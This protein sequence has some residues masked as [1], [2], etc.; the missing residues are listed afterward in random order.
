[1]G[2]RTLWKPAV[3]QGRGKDRNYFEGWYFKV[4]DADA[5]HRYAVIPGVF[6]GQTPET[7]HSF[8]QTLDGATGQA[9]YH[10]YA[11][12]DFRAAEDTFDVWVG[13]NH[14]QLDTITLDISDEQRQMQGELHFERPIGW[15]VTTFSPGIMGW[16]A[17]VP[18][19][20]TYHGVLGLDHAVSGGLTVNGQAASFDGGRGYI[21]KD[22]G[23]AFPSAHV[24]LQTNHFEQPGT[25]LTLSVATIPWLFSQFRGFIVG[26]W[27]EQVLYRFTTYTGAS[28]ARLIVSD[29]A[30]DVSL[31]G[32]AHPDSRDR[33]QLDVEVQRSQTAGVLHAPDTVD[34]IQR[35]AES[36]TSDVKVRLTNLTTQTPV[37]QGVGKYA[38]VETSGQLA[39]II[40][41]QTS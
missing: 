26:F 18:F 11:L 10:R 37:F 31:V 2:W 33:Y 20:Q 21:E 40:D 24:W 8:V 19:M 3:Y 32:P 14:F 7:S 5:K 22:W 16:Y 35:V 38:G 36:M 34:M 6:Y 9:A 1:M 29:L 25:S 4:I 23:R 12:G 39:E 28:L 30:V 13:P 17:F 15:P 41:R 27:H